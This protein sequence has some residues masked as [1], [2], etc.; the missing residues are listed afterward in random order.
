MKL[1]K[2]LALLFIT[3]WIVSTLL[4]LLYSNVVQEYFQRGE[5]TI[6]LRYSI[7]LLVSVSFLIHLTVFILTNRTIVKKVRALNKEISIINRNNN[8]KGRIKE[9]STNDE[10]AVLAKDINNM[11][12]SIED[13]NKL[14]ISNEKK[15]SR[16]VEGLDN[17]Y[18]YF[19][20]LRSSG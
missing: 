6:V 2:K 17:G 10:F 11:F 9:T 20:I 1:S 16:L 12:Q 14:I 5:R 15:Y 7:V 13:S 8:L 18:A 3:S 4:Y 19:K